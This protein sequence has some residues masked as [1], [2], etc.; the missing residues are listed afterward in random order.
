MQFS[1]TL[2][3]IARPPSLAMNSH[4]FSENLDKKL[5][6]KLRRSIGRIRRTERVRRRKISRERERMF[7]RHSGKFSIDIFLDLDNAESGLI[8]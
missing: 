5:R 2:K 3:L 1:F 6:R 8:S 7:G 4:C